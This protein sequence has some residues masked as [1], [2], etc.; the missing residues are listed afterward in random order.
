MYLFIYL[1][2]I[3]CMDRE[4]QKPPGEE[5]D[6]LPAGREAT[7][8]YRSRIYIYIYIYIHTYVRTYIHTYI[9]TYIIIHTSRNISPFRN[10]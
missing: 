5:M 1:S 3:F 2:I 4:I 8:D 7:C 6:L 10:R 9:H